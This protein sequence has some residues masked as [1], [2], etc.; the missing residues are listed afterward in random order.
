MKINKSQI[1]KIAGVAG[2]LMSI[3][4][5]VLSSYCNKKEQEEIIDRK[6]RE[7]IALNH[8]KSLVDSE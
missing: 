1:I 2:T 8:Q 6:V 3:G 4:A 7:A 5:T